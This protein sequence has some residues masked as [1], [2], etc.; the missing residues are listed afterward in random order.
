VHKGT[1]I[2]GTYSEVL[3]VNSHKLVA[4]TGQHSTTVGDLISE[5]G[6]A[7]DKQLKSVQRDDVSDVYLAFSF[8]QLVSR[9]E[10]EE[11]RQALHGHKGRLEQLH[12]DQQFCSGGT[13]SHARKARKRKSFH[14]ALE[15]EERLADWHK[16][17]KASMELL[18]KCFDAWHSEMN[19]PTRI[20]KSEDNMDA[21]EYYEDGVVGL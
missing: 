10:S 9:I 3:A 20:D 1:L 6:K 15:L 21:P 2:A 17:T 11:V 16:T 18:Q 19:H 5:Y 4:V 13:T 8:T 14:S 7:F 12:I